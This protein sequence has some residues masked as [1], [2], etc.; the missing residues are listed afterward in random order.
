MM[1]SNW[2]QALFHCSNVKCC[3]WRVEVRLS[4]RRVLCEELVVEVI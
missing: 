2:E 4:I 1:E 3:G